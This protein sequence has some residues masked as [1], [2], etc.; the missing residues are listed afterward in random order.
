MRSK[1]IIVNNR[2]YRKN[3]WRFL[4]GMQ[5]FFQ[6]RQHIAVALLVAAMFLVGV[7]KISNAAVPVTEQEAKQQKADSILQITQEYIKRGLYPQAEAQLAAME[8]EC[9]PFL[10]DEQKEKAKDL[11]G[12]VQTAMAERRKIAAAIKQSDEFMDKGD[13]SSAKSLLQQVQGSPYLSEAERKMVAESLKKA[14]S[15]L[16]QQQQSLEQQAEPQITQSEPN[17]PHQPQ[18][19]S[20]TEPNQPQPQAAEPAPQPQAVVVTQPAPA[21]T[22]PVA[23]P[24]TVSAQQENSYL[25]EVRRKQAV[26]ISYTKAVVN[27][28]LNKTDEAL[29]KKDFEAARSSL[30]RAVS[31]IE[32]NQMLLGDE[33]APTKALLTQKEEQ[34]GVEEKNYSAQ[35]IQAKQ[36]EAD[37]ITKQL[38]ET[39]DTQRAQAIQKYMEQAYAFQA[40]EDYDGAMGQLNQLLAI[41][42]RNQR[43][44]IMKKTLENTIRWREQISV[45]RKSDKEEMELLLEANRQSIPYSKEYN[46]PR[47]WKD[48]TEKRKKEPERSPVDAAINKQLDQ[49]VDLSTL[50]ETTPFGEAIEILKKSADPPLS[51]VVLW[52]DLSDNA[53]IQQSTPIN[54]SGLTA[55]PLRI[56]L[57][58]ILKS[59]SSGGMVPLG[60]MIQYGTI[61]IAT[62]DNLPT[63]NENR[64]YDISELN[65]PP[66]NYDEYNGGMMGG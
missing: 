23:E 40:E 47:D 8:Q 3:F 12:Q 36:Q 33:Y 57:E 51:I 22:Q 56:G 61:T 53:F 39:M 27:D 7:V 25:Q 66:A 18:S 54:M 9:S 62:T 26:Q 11:T 37:Q 17:Q 42:P 2:N 29:V 24:N 35:Q 1:S 14:E 20:T 63:A 64:V 48:I 60:Y 34:V 5:L 59:V 41:D 4:V 50:T 30:R 21:A 43:A 49:I 45:Q 10:N 46:Y 44:L 52:K 31:T 38:R 55:I 13:A 58:S 6:M 65:S 28:A 16:T 19:A 15:G 32:H